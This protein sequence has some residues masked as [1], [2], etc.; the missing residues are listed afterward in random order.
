MIPLYVLGLL[1]RFGP[2]HGYSI[3]KLISEQ[4]ADFTLIKLPTIYYHL[5]K[6][7]KAG[8]ISASK[9]KSD[10]RPEKKVYEIT[11]QGNNEFNSLLMKTLDFECRSTF[12]SDAAFFFSDHLER[13]S[14]AESLKAHISKMEN[15]LSYLDEHKRQ[16]LRHLPEEYHKMVTI[17]FNH[18]I[19]H[20][21]A[22][23]RWAKQSYEIFCREDS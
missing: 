8:L 6:M 11:E 16:T 17:I 3:K 15:T 14:I 2:Q 5:E 10:A 18:H 13:D 9:M 1:L 20:F 21:D 12:A 19:L 23:L 4:L 7:E 22:E